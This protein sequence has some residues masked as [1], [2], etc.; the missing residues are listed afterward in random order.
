MC[1][2]ITLKLM[3][4]LKTFFGGEDEGKAD[5]TA[6]MNASAVNLSNLGEAFH[7]LLCDNAMQPLQELL[8]RAQ[9]CGRED[10][11]LLVRHPN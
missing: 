11:F 6:Q 8:Y 10:G 1:H 5:S 3:F 9:G 7:T 4:Y 2:L